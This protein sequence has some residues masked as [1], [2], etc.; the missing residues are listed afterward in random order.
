MGPGVGPHGHARLVRRGAGL[1]G[2][3]RSARDPARIGA[4]E[5]GGPARRAD[6]GGPVTRANRRH[7]ALGGARAHAPGGGRRRGHGRLRPRHQRGAALP[8]LDAGRGRQGPPTMGSQARRRRLRSR[9]GPALH[10]PAPPGGLGRRD[11]AGPDLRLGVRRRRGAAVRAVALVV[12]QPI[13]LRAVAIRA[14]AAGGSR[15]PPALGPPRLGSRPSRV[16]NVELGAARSAGRRR[17]ADDASAAGPRALSLRPGRARRGR[18]LD[19]R[20][21]VSRLAGGR[22]L[23]ERPGRA[24]GGGHA[25]DRHLPARRH[26]PPR[27]RDRQHGLRGAAGAR[28]ET[29]S[30]C[31][32]RRSGAG[33]ASPRV[34]PRS[35]CSSKS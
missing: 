19:R 28:P 16:G 30:A 20:G 3:G 4:L 32:S 22:A 15:D 17:R 18:S 1:A 14:E 33:G 7:H 2:R 31:P 34:P 21:R 12:P 35:P 6:R 8:R 24:A 29:R 25:G 9:R 5:R 27:D 10:R 11:R 23:G 26:R 13:S